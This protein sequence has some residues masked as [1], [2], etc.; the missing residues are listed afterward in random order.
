MALNRGFLY[1]GAKNVVY[2][3]FK[4]YDKQSCELTIELFKQLIA[5]QPSI[6][7]LHQA[8]LN[9][10]TRGLMPN[11]WAGYVLVGQ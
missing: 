2:T 5:Q 6:E 8:K 10:I 1:S 4:V 9:L 7:A 3:L 11:K